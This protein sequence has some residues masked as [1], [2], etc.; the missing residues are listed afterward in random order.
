MGTTVSVWLVCHSPRARPPGTSETVFES[1][2]RAC[3]LKYVLFALIQWITFPKNLFFNIFH[4]AGI[5]T[6]VPHSPGR[7]S[8]MSIF[9]QSRESQKIS[10]SKIII[11][12]SSSKNRMAKAKSTTKLNKGIGYTTLSASLR[13]STPSVFPLPSLCELLQISYFY[14]KNT[15]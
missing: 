15:A 5:H 8:R 10:P 13:F 7:R 6:G 4:V 12:S 3:I 2:Q 9:Q 11:I 14:F 1:T